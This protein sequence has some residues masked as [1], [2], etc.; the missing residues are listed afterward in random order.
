M[1]AR[2]QA[3]SGTVRGA[4]DGG[5]GAPVKG[6]RAGAKQ[7]VSSGISPAGSIF[8]APVTRILL[9]GL[10]SAITS[11]PLFSPPLDESEVRIIWIPL[12]LLSYA[13]T[14]LPRRE[15]P[16][17]ALIYTAVALSREGEFNIGFD[18]TTIA[19]QIAMAAALAVA[20]P[21]HL[22]RRQ[23]IMQPTRVIAYIVLTLLITLIGAS[24]RLAAAAAFDLSPAEWLAEAGGDA[25]HA[26]RHWWL[27]NACAFVT[28]TGSLTFLS[29]TRRDDWAEVFGVPGE[30]R[31]FAFLA[32]LQLAAT[33]FVLPVADQSRVG[34]PADIRLGLLLVPMMMAIA[35]TIRFKG[36]GTAFALLSTT[37][38]AAMSLGGPFADR[39][40]AGLPSMA[41][42]VQLLL[43]VAA[44]TCWVLA[45]TLRHLQ[46]AIRDAVEAGETKSRFIALMSHE[47]RTPLNAI[48]GFSELMRM[49]SLRQLGKEVATLDNIHASGQR[50]LAMVDALLNHAGG[51]E[52]IFELRKEPLHLRSAVGGA[53]AE[54]VDDI[55][56][57]DCVVEV[58]IPDEMFLEAD[59]R[60]LRQILLVLIGNSLR[61]SEK[62]NSISISAHHAGT[63]S[64]VEIRSNKPKSPAGDDSDKVES[65]LV[66][67]LVL[68]HGARLTLRTIPQSGHLAR[69]KFFATRAAD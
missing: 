20:V 6:G 67:A 31:T 58:D 18:A 54:L 25:A 27:G 11:L 55:R 17:Y 19:I 36:I 48:L 35:L 33:A 22:T 29:Q 69:L 14:W 62:G 10:A 4:R 32:G 59:P 37:L 52:T 3:R 56:E 30:R 39:N 60:A 12:A 66:N 44:A 42:P 15:A 24:L 23:M 28:V 64:I 61:L 2:S 43:I 9:F 1:A 41:T 38:I 53:V 65:H 51:G 50:L 16:I 49:Q 45:T 40:W 34:L 7:A 46:W 47:L 8:G 13:F 21:R 63:D 68:A 5:A 57:C 26:W